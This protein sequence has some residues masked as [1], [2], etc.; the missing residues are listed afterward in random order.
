MS[1]KATLAAGGL[2]DEQFDRL[3][4]EFQNDI[5]SLSGVDLVTQ[6]AVVPSP[7]RR[8]DAVTFGTFAPALVTSGAVTALFAICKSYVERGIE[9]SFEGVDI[10]GKPVKISSKGISSLDQF[11]AFLTS[12]GVL[13]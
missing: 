3:A 7:R 6:E 10:N 13:K 4:R 11:K 9:V 8:G 1:I 5:A 12:A 2:S